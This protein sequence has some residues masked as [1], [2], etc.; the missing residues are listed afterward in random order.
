MYSK[1]EMFLA[2]TFSLIAGFAVG[3]S[4]AR[5]LCLQAI[6]TATGTSDKDSEE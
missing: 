5:E 6:M 1:K 4:K 2:V 3:Y